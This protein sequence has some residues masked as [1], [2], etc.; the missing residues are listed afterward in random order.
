[1][2]RAQTGPDSMAS[3]SVGQQPDELQAIAYE[4]WANLLQSFDPRTEV[5]PALLMTVFQDLR[6][7]LECS[8]DAY[9]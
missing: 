4:Q 3:P 9:R 8:R 1:M 5:I 2:A 7:H 6:F